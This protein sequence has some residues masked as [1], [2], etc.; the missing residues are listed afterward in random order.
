MEHSIDREKVIEGLEV[1]INRVPG[2]YD[3]NK[4]PYEIDGN[5][6]EINLAKDALALL[7]EQDDEIAKFCGEVARLTAMLEEQDEPKQIVRKQCKKEHEDGSIDYF[8]EWYCP[9]C[10]SLIARGF[11]NPS[12]KFCYKCGKPILWEGR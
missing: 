6:C 4:C 2:K 12:I 1:C 7:K 10:K 5:Y 9:H 3:C 8:A 11:D